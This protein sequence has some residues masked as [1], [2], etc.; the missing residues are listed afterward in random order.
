MKLTIAN[1]RVIDPGAN[2]D[3]VG[4]LHIDDGVIVAWG[5]A[6]PGFAQARI[7]E[8][9]GLIACPGLIDL[10]ARLR[11]PGAT[12]KA[13]IASEARAAARGG[14]TTLCCPPD[15]DPVIDEAATV[16]LIHRRAADAGAARVLPIAAL[17]LDLA[18][19][20][21]AEMGTLKAAGC[22]AVSNARVPVEDTRVMRRALEYAATHELPVFLQ[23]SDPWLA[24]QGCAH[25]GEV[26]TRLG[27]A[28]TPSAAETVALA[29]LL[30]LVASTGVR[31]HFGQLSA[32]RSLSLVSAARQSG[33]EVT[34]DAGVAHLHLSEFDVLGF[35]SRCHVDPPLRTQR[36]RDALREAACTGLLTAVCSD[37][38]PHEPDA[39]LAPFPSTEP[40]ISGL[41]TLLSLMLKLVMEDVMPLRQALALLTSGPAGVLGIAHGSLAPGAPADVCL[42]DPHAEWEVSE[43]TLASRGHNTPFTGWHLPGR[44]RAVVIGGELRAFD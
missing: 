5:V 8:A 27:L 37:H 44:V 40:G 35:D 22:V 12:H 19:E 11:E 20:R 15:T 33:L 16:E 31:A 21:L 13:T 39:K 17:T 14:I 41:D 36:D 3:E 38:Q 34:A 29:K 26:A 10:W 28:G 23:A 2:R 9:G 43:A 30:E 18:G 25:E 7:F 4:S 42:F 32:A 1:A 6:P 24:R